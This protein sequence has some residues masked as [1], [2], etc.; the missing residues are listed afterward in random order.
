MHEDFAIVYI[1]PLPGNVLNFGGVHEVVHEFLNE[2]MGVRVKDIQPSHLGQALVWFS[3]VHDRDVLVTNS[4]YAYGDVRFSV[5]RHNQARNWRAMN[6]NRECC[7]ML[8]G[9]PLDYWDNETIQNSIASFGRMLLWENDRSHLTIL[10]V[11]ARVSDL[12]DVPHFILLTEGEGFMG[13]SWTIQCKIL[14]QELFGAVP[15]DDDPVPEVQAN[16]QPPLFDFFGLGLPVAGHVNFHHNEEGFG[17]EN[18]KDA[19]PDQ[20]APN[21]APE[22]ADPNQQHEVLFDLNDVP[23]V[24]AVDALEDFEEGLG[25]D[26]LVAQNDVVLLPGVN[27]DLDF[28]FPQQR[29]APW[30]PQLEDQNLNDLPPQAEETPIS[31]VANSFNYD[32]TSSEGEVEESLV[33]PAK[34]VIVLGLHAMAINFMH[35][36]LQPHE[37][38]A[39]EESLGSGGNDLPEGSQSS[40]HM[41]EVNNDEGTT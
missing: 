5:V 12:Q 18:A 27:V 19:M 11:K 29:V 6:F 20:A 9:F 26:D 31:M 4:P 34:P 38:N 37:S 8:M 2:H 40:V 7:L 16:G 28:M 33:A 3:Q 13:Q 10:L 22:N 24:E 1:D 15:A 17:Q 35:L 30:V 21:D 41:A 32:G 14:E 39:L 36:E 25:L 23:M